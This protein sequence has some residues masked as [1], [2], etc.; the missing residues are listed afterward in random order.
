MKLICTAMAMLLI[1]V[2]VFLPGCT[3]TPIRIGFSGQ[4]SGVGSDIGV[5]GRNGATYALEEIN[6]RGGIAGKNLELISVDDGASPEEAVDADSELIEAGVR[7]IIGHTTST[8]TLAALPF[9]ERLGI[10]LVTPNASSPKLEGASPLLYRM[11]S[12]STRSAQ[13]MAAYAKGEMG[14]I[15]IIPVL[16]RDNEILV[17]SFSGDFTNAFTRLGGK[18][19]EPI[20]FSSRNLKSWDEITATVEGSEATGV[21]ILATSTD[22]AAFANALKKRYALYSGGWAYTDALLRFGG[23]AVEG[24]VFADTFSEGMRTDPRYLAFAEGYRQRF[25]K[26]PSFSS[27]QAHDALVFLSLGMEKAERDKIELGQALKT[28]REFEGVYSTIRLTEGGEALRPVY[29]SRIVDGT[30]VTVK[31]VEAGGGEE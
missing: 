5:D 26:E 12:S 19:L 7:A 6:S 4:L 10:P 25:G 3:R 22:T 27:T 31:R 17:A 23:K 8:N 2:L 30:F 20:W 15:T 14:C 18:T 21:L 29:V 9:L 16:D 24:M 1:L 11:N 13:V 28:I